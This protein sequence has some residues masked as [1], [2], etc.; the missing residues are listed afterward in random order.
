[1]HVLLCMILLLG[2]APGRMDIYPLA[3]T[4]VEAE[5]LVDSLG[6]EYAGLK[7]GLQPHWATSAG[8]PGHDG[9]L[10]RYTPQNVGRSLRMSF[11]FRRSLESFSEDSLSMEGWIDRELLLLEIR[12]HEY[13]FAGQAMWRRSPLPYT[14]ALIEGITSVLPAR[15]LDSL[16]EYLASRLRAVPDVIADARTNVTDP[17]SLHC[18]VARDDLA[19]LADVLAGIRAGADPWVDTT[20]VTLDLLE[21]AGAA[22][23]A[24]MDDLGALAENG[25]PDYML[26][27]EGYAGF[28]REC[29]ML[30]E[31]P[32]DILAQSERV[33]EQAQARL[34][35]LGWP[36]A[37]AGSGRPE[38]GACMLEIRRALD[39][40]EDLLPFTRLPEDSLLSARLMPCLDPVVDGLVYRP[41]GG[42]G[43]GRAE[44]LLTGSGRPVPAREDESGWRIRGIMRTYYPAEHLIRV[45]MDRRS[46]CIR[47]YFG[48][49][50][51]RDGWALYFR[52]NML[53]PGGERRDAE[54]RLWADMAF[55]AASSIAEIKIHTGAMTLDEAADF[56]SRAARRPRGLCL[57]DARGY[58]VAPGS[59][60]GYLIGRREILMLKE[61]YEKVK[62]KSFDLKEF[63]DTLLSCGYLPPYLLSIEVMSKGMG[64]E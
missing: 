8:F 59:G 1:L 44:V 18:E 12:T 26:G 6:C 30:D 55:Y 31:C 4:R 19:G 38:V 63:H 34:R 7:A 27:A 28:L 46:S 54:S 61:R 57:R 48:S 15:D 35:D 5:G 29:H 22:V 58:A 9:D 36:Q 2:Q 25:S 43:R 33:L 60:I 64:R 17:I 52:E 45:R 23:S 13:W 62:R 56:M 42:S 16:S 49:S 47:R 10:A 24:Y 14:Q 41:A 3:L 51:T 21:R 39:L 53:P 40:M 20:V 50:I 37:A 11:N 32:G